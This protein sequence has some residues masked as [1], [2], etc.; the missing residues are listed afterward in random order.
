MYGKGTI[1]REGDGLWAELV[2]QFAAIPGTRQIVV[3]DVT[4]VQTS[5]GFG[6]PLMQAEQPRTLLTDWAEKKGAEGLAEYR[7]KKNKTSIDG[8]PTGI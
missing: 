2:G 4:R 1:V 5:C 7:Q 8:L 3:V 6:V